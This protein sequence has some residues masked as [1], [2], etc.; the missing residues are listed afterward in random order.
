[1]VAFRG[2]CYELNTTRVDWFTAR[3]FCAGMSQAALL[4]IN[5]EKEA[6]FVASI[7]KTST[8]LAKPDASGVWLGQQRM[9]LSPSSLPVFE[10]WAC[11]HPAGHVSCMSASLNGRDWKEEN[12]S[13]KKAFF[14]EKGMLL[15]SRSRS[16]LMSIFS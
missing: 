5:D 13:N 11:G 8:D 6:D 14:C 7:L 1:M 15:L 12:C 4:D 3:S 2:R 16:F 9:R 10:P